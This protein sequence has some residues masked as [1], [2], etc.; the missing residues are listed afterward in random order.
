MF[1]VI[2]KLFWLKSNHG[3]KNQPLKN[4]KAEKSGV[5][6]NAKADYA[7]KKLITKL[8]FQTGNAS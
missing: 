4:A 5:T 6:L 1:G 7:A 2:K 3:G 8:S